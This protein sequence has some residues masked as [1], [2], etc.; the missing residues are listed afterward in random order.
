MTNQL[1]ELTLITRTLLLVLAVIFLSQAASAQQK[2]AEPKLA[3]LEFLLGKWV[4]EGSSE[5]GTGSGYFTFETSLQGKALVRR[6]YA[7]YPATKD[8]PPSKHDDLMI[9]YV[10]TATKMLRAF[11]A[12]S[13][14]HAI[15]YAISISDDRKSVVF[16]SDAQTGVPRYRLTYTVTQPDR[17][18]V[19]LEMAPADKPDQFKKIVEGKVRRAA[20]K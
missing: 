18:S 5:A 11:Y 20:S 7:E 1:S 2:P 6:N 15:S 3:P 19:T 8:R 12:D 16:L 9:V 13:E 4:G 10:D 14:E 17:M